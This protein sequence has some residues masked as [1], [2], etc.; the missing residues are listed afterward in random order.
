MILGNRIY[1]KSKM[2]M[3]LIAGGGL[4]VE[5]NAPNAMNDTT[6]PF[7]NTTHMNALNV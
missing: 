5:N 7:P 2:E 6:M 4:T 3:R 1:Y